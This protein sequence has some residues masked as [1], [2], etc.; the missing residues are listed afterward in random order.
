MIVL[1]DICYSFRRDCLV[2][3]HIH[4]TFE[5]KKYAL[6][7]DNGCGKT[8]LFRC[9]SGYYK[10]QQGEII[11]ENGEGIQVGYL[12]QKF[13]LYRNMSVYENLEYLAMLR[14]FPL[15]NER[16]DDL[17]GL[18][19][20]EKERHKKVKELSGGMMQRVGI[21]QALLGNPD[22]LLLDE[23]TAGLDITQ[24]KNFYELIQDFDLN[25]PVIMSSH[26]PEDAKQMAEEIIVMKQ[27]SLHLTDWNPKVDNIEERYLCFRV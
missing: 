18:L 27:G 14:G 8:T 20:L 25:I 10:M 13:G 21:A 12:P 3:N 6:L 2:L 11:T 4:F 17:I 9:I 1:K 5:N 22:I 15:Q 7:G 19:Q 26:F 23:P 16:I 24:R